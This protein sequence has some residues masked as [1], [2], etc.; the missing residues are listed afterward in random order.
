MTIKAI[1]SGL[2]TIQQY[3]VLMRADVVFADRCGRYYSGPVGPITE[4][5]LRPKESEREKKK[6]AQ[7]PSGTL[8]TPTTT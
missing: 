5:M 1:L 7:A 6:E 3:D 8:E 2:P 4:S